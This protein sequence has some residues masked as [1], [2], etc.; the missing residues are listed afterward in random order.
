MRRYLVGTAILAAALVLPSLAAAK[1]P[2]SASLSGP[3]LGR[4]LAVR[5]QGEM[6]PGTPLG[7][8]VDLGG[9]FPQMFGQTPDTTVKAKPKGTLGKRY[10][11]VYVV[12]GPNGIR[13]RVVQSVYP[14]A[15]PV[16][17]TYMK[18]GQ[19]FW[20]SDRTYGGWYVASADL[21]STLV[22]AGLPAKPPSQA[23][24]GFWTVG[25]IS[26]IAS[27]LALIALVAVVRPWNRRN[28]RFGAA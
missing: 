17:V 14:Y 12:P 1:G 25:V 21:K 24:A 15:K 9:F 27:V 28:G 13:S 4:S 10:T 20:E 2:E 19:K 11:I 3:G 8:L 22:R 5:G 18:P 6:G 23:S 7:A 16:P 26:G